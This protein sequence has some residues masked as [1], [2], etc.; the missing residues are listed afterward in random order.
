MPLQDEK[1]EIS[2]YPGK[3]LDA[4]AIDQH[5]YVELNF[6]GCP[7]HALVDTGA[8]RTVLRRHEY[9]ILRRIT[10]RTAILDQA[11]DLIGVTG[12]DLQ[13]LGKT[14]LQEKTL[15]IVTV[16][17]VDNIGH[18]MILG[19]DALAP[20]GARIDY[21]Q[22]IITWRKHLLHLIPASAPP[23]IMNSLGENPP[24]HH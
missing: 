12:H 17:I 22:G 10:G 3:P 23:A 7:I 1:P 13:V 18:P 6:Y 15:G 4:A 9:E 11:A 24:P 16:I 8:S 14:Q 5:V 20:D 21:Q 2:R 19:R